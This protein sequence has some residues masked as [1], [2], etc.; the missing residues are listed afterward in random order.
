V[1]IDQVASYKFKD[2]TKDTNYVDTPKRLEIQPKLQK[3]GI[4]GCVADRDIR[5]AK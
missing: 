5:N 2:V 4:L 3:K 1:I